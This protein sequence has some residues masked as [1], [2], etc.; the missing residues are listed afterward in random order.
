MKMLGEQ[1][2]YKSQIAFKSRLGFRDHVLSD[3]NQGVDFFAAATLLEN[4]L[5]DDFLGTNTRG[6]LYTKSEAIERV[7]SR[8][9]SANHLDKIKIRFFG[10]NLAVLHGSESSSAKSARMR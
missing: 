2:D 1:F 4:V 10:N 3:R 6:E 8:M 9:R 5:A 7:K